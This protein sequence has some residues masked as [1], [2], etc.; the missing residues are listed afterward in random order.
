MDTAQEKGSS[1]VMEHISIDR[2]LYEK[3]DQKENTSELIRK[4]LRAFYAY[5]EAKQTIEY[6]NGYYE[7]KA[8]GY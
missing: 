4:L 8:P 2:D 1:E 3:L 7:E 6:A 5:Q